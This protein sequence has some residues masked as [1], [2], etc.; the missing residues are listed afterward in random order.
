[1]KALA[2]IDGDVIALEQARVALDDPGYL[3][4][5]GAFE[6]LRSRRGRVLR[7]DLHAERMAYGLAVLDIDAQALGVAERAVHE[8]AAAARDQNDV[9]LRVQIT[10]DRAGRGRVT[11]LARSLPAYPDRLYRQGARLSVADWRRDPDD[12]LAGVK[13]MSY[14]A[15]VNTRRHARTRGFDDALILNTHGRVCEASYANVMARSGEVILAPGRKEGAL[16]GVTRQVLLDALDAGRYA[17]QARLDWSELE[18]AEEVVL[19]ST[20][21]GVIPVAHI[22]GIDRDYIGASGVFARRMTQCYA[23]LLEAE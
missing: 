5:D 3:L 16:D 17:L 7:W 13:S 9:Y 14:L 12:P 2:W 21:A 4:G 20:L 8:L 10:R 19:V 6:T 11:V 15:Q 22:E 23:D 18:S 1:M